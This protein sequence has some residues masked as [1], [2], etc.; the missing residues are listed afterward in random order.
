MMNNLFSYFQNLI[1]SSF[2]DITSG[3]LSSLIYAIGGFLLSFFLSKSKLFFSTIKYRRLKSI[4][5]I[6]KNEKIYILIGS[7]IHI[8]N[9]KYSY[10][11]ISNPIVFILFKLEKLLLKLY[12]KTEIKIV[13]DIESIGQDIN[14]NLILIGG[15]GINP[16]VYNLVKD[17]KITFHNSENIKEDRFYKDSLDN[18]YYVDHSDDTK[19]IDYGIL[20]LIKNPLSPT[21]KIITLCGIETFGSCAAVNSFLNF[22]RIIKKSFNI[23]QRIQIKFTSEIEILTKIKGIGNVYGDELKII[24]I[25]YKNPYNSKSFKTNFKIKTLEQ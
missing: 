14:Q 11:S 24:D 13:F 22:D 25:N 6:R 9:S 20:S 21:R 1:E 5:R 16:L 19:T 7:N 2:S 17:K 18:K 3:I 4:L 8:S 23:I 15:P 10:G 12:P